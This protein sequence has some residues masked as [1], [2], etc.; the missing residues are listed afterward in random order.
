MA[1]QSWDERASVLPESLI[2]PHQLHMAH[3]EPLGDLVERHDGRV[4]LALLEFAQILLAEAAALRELLLGQAALLPEAREVSADE[5]AHVHP[6]MLA[7]GGVRSLSTIICIPRLRSSRFPGMG[8]GVSDEPLSTGPVAVRLRDAAMRLAAELDEARLY[9]AA[10]YASMAADAA[11]E[12]PAKVLT[13]DEMRTDVE[14]D[15]ELDEHGRVWMIREGDC[16]I[17][18]RREAVCAKMRRFLASVVLGESR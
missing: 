11:G 9:R 3:A 18:G 1:C 5:L 10:A 16:H 17:I 15:F 13:P 4:A 12:P 14:T 7:F 2:L 6:P 8:G